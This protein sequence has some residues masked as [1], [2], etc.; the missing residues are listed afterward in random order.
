VIWILVALAF[1][2]GTPATQPLK[3]KP[4]SWA[5][6]D[7]CEAFHA[8]K[9]GHD[10]EERLRA[11]VADALGIEVSDVDIRQVCISEQDKSI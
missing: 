2:G 1:V 10:A 5:T 11:A 8:S 3:Y 6:K 7:E 9:E 4:A